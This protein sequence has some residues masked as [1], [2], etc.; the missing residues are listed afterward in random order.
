VTC[1]VAQ[2]PSTFTAAGKPLAGEF[3]RLVLATFHG[4][5]G[6]RLLRSDTAVACTKNV[7][8]PDQIELDSEGGTDL[9]T[10]LV[11][12]CEE[13]AFTQSETG[14]DGTRHRSAAK[15]CWAARSRLSHKRW[16]GR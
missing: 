11:A 9:A 7:F 8:R 16:D 4:E 3:A 15:T 1:G 6:R 2:T 10:L 14:C 12:A 5:Q 13:D